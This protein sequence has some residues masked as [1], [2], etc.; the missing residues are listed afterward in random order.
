MARQAKK[1]KEDNPLLTALRFVSVAQREEGVT[2]QTHCRFADGY[3]TAFDGALAAGFP[4]QEEWE[5]CP[6]TLKLIAALERVT[7]A[8]SLTALDNK[9]LAVNSEKFRATISCHGG[10]DLMKIAPDPAMYPINDT[11]KQAADIAGTFNQDGAQLMVDASVCT[12]DGS[13]VGCTSRTIIECWHGI[14]TPPGLIIPKLFVSILMKIKTPMSRFG[15]SPQSFTVWFEDGSWLRTNLFIEQYAAYGPV[16]TKS[17]AANPS[18]I[19]KEIFEGIR[20]VAPF[21]GDT[22]VWAG[23]SC[24]RSQFDPRHAKAIYDVKALAG[25][26][27]VG[28]NI[29][30]MLALEALIERIDYSVQD[31]IAWFGGNARGVIAS[32]RPPTNVDDDIPF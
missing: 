10:G 30:Q 15:F 29:K 31:V 8:A 27:M 9:T 19:I 1:P 24:V 11:W 2:Y 22:I 5:L 16:I 18:P 23:D 21:A 28:L 7:G 20:K 14:P 17:E 6:H 12:A 26:P 4:V 32:V 3:V 13:V 25:M